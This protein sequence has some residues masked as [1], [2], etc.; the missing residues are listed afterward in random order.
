MEAVR[1]SY[2]APADKIA[3]RFVAARLNGVAL[4]E[5]PGP[6]PPNLEAAYSC[7]DAAI[8][9]WPDEVAGWKIGRIPQEY[10]QKLGAQRLAGPI[11]RREV[12]RSVPG[13][14]VEF[15]IYVGG[16][17]AVEAEYIFEI[18]R[19]APAGKINWSLEDASGIA[20]RMFV[21]IETAGSPLSMINVLGPT[22]TVSDFGNNAGLILGPE[23]PDWRER[24]AAQLTCETF[25]YGKSVGAGG[26]KNVLGGLLESV[27][28]VAGS[29]AER[30]RPLK[31]GMLI[32]TG[33]TT[34]IHEI[35]TGQM[36]RVEFNGI[37]S[38]Q[39]VAK[40]AEKI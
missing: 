23:V 14:P 19:D 35:I 39:C 34:G 7:Q 4:A 11:F 22:V 25:I 8:A 32:S 16:F 38:I 40:P 30:G 27:R 37:G 18:V 13:V 33:A 28:F 2:F 20:G 15:G 12:R 36:A 31:A 29:C 21:G 9:L 17:A 24:T 6:I 3:Q 10:A 26:A 1:A 5:Y